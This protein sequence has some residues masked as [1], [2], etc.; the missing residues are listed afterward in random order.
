MDPELCLW[1]G[2]GVWVKVKVSVRDRVS[3]EIMIRVPLWSQ[4]W[5]ACSLFPPGW[6]TGTSAMVALFVGG[7]QVWDLG[8]LVPRLL[9]YLAAV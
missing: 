9:C 6:H 2:V 3:V 5:G 4:S 7:L 8:C 1:F